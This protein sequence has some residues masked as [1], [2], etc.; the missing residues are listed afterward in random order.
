VTPEPD[1]S[2]P[3]VTFGD[4]LE[5]FDTPDTVNAL[6]RSMREAQ[7]IFSRVQSYDDELARR[8]D[9]IKKVT[10]NLSSCFRN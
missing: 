2:P 1:G 8:R 5:E 7:S 10:G 3:T 9:F 6:N 4:E